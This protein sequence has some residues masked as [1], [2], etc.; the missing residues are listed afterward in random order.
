MNKA[1]KLTI[2]GRVQ[3]VGYRNFVYNKALKLGLTGYVRNCSDGSVETVISGNEDHLE[4][5]IRDLETGPLLA[6]VD[7]IV[8]ENFDQ[9]LNTHNFRIIL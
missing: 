7:R 4:V 5:M 9:D 6:R 1:L 3:G 8:R 2:Y